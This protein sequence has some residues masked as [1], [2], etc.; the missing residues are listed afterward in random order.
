MGFDDADRVGRFVNSPVRFGKWGSRNCSE[1]NAYV[2]IG[3]CCAAQALNPDHPHEVE[4]WGR[5]VRACA[6]LRE[7]VSAGVVE[8]IEVPA[9]KFASFEFTHSTVR[10]GL[11]RLPVGALCEAGA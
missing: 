10:L 4:D 8:E 3:S 2:Y 1:P 11:Y 5:W 7:K 9:H 6:A